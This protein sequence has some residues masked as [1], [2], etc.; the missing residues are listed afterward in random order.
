MKISLDIKILWPNYWNETIPGLCS[1]IKGLRHIQNSA[2][3]TPSGPPKLRGPV[4]PK[5]RLFFSKNFQG[6]MT[7]GYPFV[8]KTG[9][10]HNLGRFPR[11]KLWGIGRHLGAICTQQGPFSWRKT[12]NISFKTSRV[13]APSPIPQF[14][15]LKTWLLRPGPAGATKGPPAPHIGLF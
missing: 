14:V 6:P 15:L 5:T 13:A 2:A 9:P 3:K 10:G 1:V 12:N 4:P 7:P 11:T 8:L